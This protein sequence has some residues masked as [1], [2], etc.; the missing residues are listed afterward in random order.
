MNTTTNYSLP[1]WEDTDRVTR[2]DMN[3]AMQ[4]IDTAIKAVAD[5]GL[6]IQTGS[7]TG[8]GTYGANNKMSLTF[9]FVPKLV[10]CADTGFNLNFNNG[11]ADNSFYRLLL[12]HML[13]TESENWWVQG[14]FGGQTI[15]ELPI[16]VLSDDRKTVYWY[17]YTSAQGQANESGKTYHYLA[18]G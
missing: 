7:Y 11:G 8:T 15:T 14:G 6:R 17:S 10:I 1:Q 16:A 9:D 3:D 5:G 12:P 18:I 2:G 13:H 4:S